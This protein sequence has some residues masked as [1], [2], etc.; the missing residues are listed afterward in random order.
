M[1][2]RAPL[3]LHPD[4]L[5]P[6]EPGRARGRA[7]AVRRG[8]RPADDLA[9]RPRRRRG[10]CSTTSRSRDPATLLVT[11]DHY[12]TRLLHA[13][14]VPL[15]ALGVGQGPLAEARVARRSGGR[16]ART[17]TSSAARPSRFWLEA[18]LAEI[19]DVTVRPSAADRRRDLRPARRA[20][21]RR[22][23]T[24]RARCSSGSASRCWPPPTTR[25]TTWPR[26]P[27]WPP[28]RRGPGRVIPTFR[29]DRYL[30]PAAAG[31]GAT[32][33]RGSARCAG[34]D[35][36]ELRRLR[37]ARWSS[38]G[39]HFVAH[40]ADVG[41][42][43]PRGRRAPTR[44]TPAEAERI[45]RA[46]LAGDATR[47]RGRRVAPAHAAGDGPDVVRGRAGDDA[48][49]GRAPQPPPADGRARSA[50]TPAT[51]S[52]CASSSPTRCARCSSASA[53]TRTSTWSL[54]TLDET[55]WSRELAPLAGFYPSVYVGAPWWFLDAPG[56]RSG[57]SA[58]AVTET[59]G[60]LA[61]VGLH[62]RHPRVLLDPGPPRHVPPPRRRLP[63]PA[64][65]RAPARRGRGASR[66]R[67]TWSTGRPTRGVQAVTARSRAAPARAAPPVRARAPRARQ[68][69]PRPPG[70]VHRPRARRRRLGHRRVHRP[71]RRTSPTRSTAQDGL[72]TLVTRGGRRRPLRGGRAACRARTRPTTTTPGCGYLGSPGR[73]RWSRSPSP[74]PATCAAPT[75]GSTRAPEVAPT[76][77]RCARPGRAV[78]TAPARLLAGLAARRRADAGPLALVP[79]DNLPDNGAVA[80]AA[81]CATSPSS[82]TRPAR[83]AGRRRVGRVTTMVDRITPAADR[84]RPRAPS[85]PATGRRR[86]QPGGHRAVQRVGA[87]RRLPRRAAGAGRP[88]ARRSPTT[89]R[90]FEQRKLWLLNGGAL[91]ARLR[92]LAARATRPSP[93]R[94]PTTACRALA[95]AVVGRGC[96]PHLTLPAGPRSRPTAPRCSSG[97]PT[98]ASGTRS[99]RSPRTARRSCRSGSCPCCGGARRRPAARGAVAGAGGVAAALCGGSGP[100]CSDVR[101]G[102]L[103]P[104]AAAG[105]S[106]TASPRVLAALGPEL[107]DDAELVSAVSTCVGGA[108]PSLIQCAFGRVVV[109]RRGCPTVPVLRSLP[110]SGD[111]HEG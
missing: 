99:T 6:A 101:G 83:L 39:A 44:S 9:A 76:S 18:E 84:R 17:G 38:A 102:E 25:A 95:R 28:T 19:F 98:R 13:A 54:F 87:Q 33:S 47:G 82:S 12:V 94:S 37:R 23:P 100:R 77:T 22:T 58:R 70:L 65:G 2:R 16:C 51:T 57:A 63:R 89:S 80:R 61:H 30:E 105:R 36:G 4:R 24:G 40:G 74:R 111:R 41:R 53:R 62:R 48:A 67:S 109:H 20:A 69:L 5:L 34:V 91:A 10:C 1:P 96:A 3:A 52:R 29:P 35:T 73:A 66:R 21:R 32:R 97:S 31:L 15:D 106:P 103:R 60:L 104:L 27:R 11:P 90:P 49:P 56:R 46:A 86:P 26:T 8:A 107:G 108:A 45:Y 50:P 55:V 59:A 88:P 64:G 78:R 93:R 43:Q 68:L 14:G 42:P 110:W 81:S 85:W 92:R 79:C 7:A 72:Y 71:P 75:A